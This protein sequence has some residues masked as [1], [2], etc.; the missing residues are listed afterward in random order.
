MNINKFTKSN[1]I[2]PT[3]CFVFAFL[4]FSNT[5]NH[6]F[7]LD[8]YDAYANN[9]VVKKGIQGIP[10]I[11]KT[12][13]RYGIDMLCDN[14]YRPLSQI[15]FAVEWQIA[16]NKPHLS[17]FINVLFYALSCL[18]L[19]IV[20]RKYLNKSHPLIP[21]LITIFYI[22][23][24]IHTEVVANIKSRDEIM[25]FLFLL[26]TFLCLYK[27][28]TGNKWWKWLFLFI[29]LGMFF[30]S[31]MSKEGVVTMLFLFPIIGWYFT[32]AKLKSILISSLLMLFPAVAYIA[33]RY[34]VLSNMCNSVTIPIITNFLVGATD[35]VSHFATALMLLGK[36]L[37]LSILP[38]QLV[39]NYTYNQI[40]I[41]GL[42][43][44]K[45][46]IS[47]LVYLTIGIYVILN[48]RKKKPLV[49]GLLFFL[50]T[51]SIYSNVFFHIGT[52]FGERLVFIP[53]LGLCISLVY[54]ITQW[55]KVGI[56]NKNK[57][58]IEVIKSKPIFTTIFIIIL[59][60][61]SAK[62][63]I[64]AAEWKSEAILYEKDIKRS[65]NSASLC[66]WYGNTLVEKANKENEKDKKD[67][68]LYQALSYFDK[69]ISIYP[70][71]T[72]CLEQ[73]DYTYIE[74]SDFKNAFV[75]ANKALRLDS[76]KAVTWYNIGLCYYEFGN[77]QLAL[78]FYNKS[79]SKDSRYSKA[80]LN[81]GRILGE[82]QKYEESIVYF[83][84]CLQYDPENITAHNNIGLSYKNLNK[85][86][87]AKIWFGKARMIEQNLKKEK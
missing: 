1:F 13:Y 79:L 14:I 12:N 85:L 60:T 64:R 83:K 24:P 69:C 9:S 63:V 57:S 53:T 75:Y 59:I 25:A 50:I 26:L 52:S 40:P 10:I 78:E 47:V 45:F 11:L 76:T 18:L 46:L 6:S 55:L 86:E 7:V 17:H 29:S 4:L 19:F 3:I 67:A 73:I 37:L 27:W 44:P 70:D 54:I 84:K 68:F 41:I 77:T 8:D 66:Y 82:T 51:I 65:P 2:L 71:Y 81:I 34:Y 49:F 15:M 56:I 28:F 20:L 5:F 33:I 36:Y 16:P 72:D 87:E 61:F 31:L 80:Y 58:I 32:D 21:F 42:S 38:Y 30:L 35:P 62:T 43:N 22:A 23:M 48:I 74:L 39:S